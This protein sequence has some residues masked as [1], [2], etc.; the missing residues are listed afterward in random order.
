MNDQNDRDELWK[1]IGKP[2]PAGG[3]VKTIYIGA[4]ILFLLYLI[5]PIPEYKIPLYRHV[6]VELVVNGEPVII[7]RNVKCSSY[8]S[9]SGTGKLFPSLTVPTYYYPTVRRIGHKL[10]DG[11]YL[12]MPMLSPC[13]KDADYM[14]VA[15]PIEDG[16]R[17]PVALAPNEHT[18]EGVL[19]YDHNNAYNHPDAQ[20]RDISFTVTEGDFW[21]SVDDDPEDAW[22]IS[23]YLGS[24]SNETKKQRSLEGAGPYNWYVFF[25]L[26]DDL[27]D[28]FI[29]LLD[30]EIPEVGQDVWIYAPRGEVNV[31][32]K[33]IRKLCPDYQ[34]SNPR[35]YGDNSSH[36]L[37]R[38]R[39]LVPRAPTFDPVMPP[40]R[41][42]N[43][44]SFPSDAPIGKRLHIFSLWQDG[45]IQYRDHLLELPD[46]FTMSNAGAVVDRERRTV[47]LFASRP[48]RGHASRKTQNYIDQ[49][50]ED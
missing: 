39:L 31:V 46:S 6:K 18:V 40:L 13:F 36:Q 19:I 41:E 7:E 27:Y 38:G 30:V 34:S 35:D 14:G 24:I 50:K 3:S 4:G 20:I 8:R 32:L 43:V 23:P 12:M 48:G 42:G 49:I 5:F 9:S 10:A 17:F 33:V 26:S 44:I 1:I 29:E 37:C 45:A 21:D 47:I 22:T 15:F 28:E 11:R 16:H 25:R 2:K